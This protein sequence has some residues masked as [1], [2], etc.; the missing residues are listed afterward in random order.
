MHTPDPDRRAEL[1]AAAVA[2]ELTPAEAAELDALRT[3]DP[4]I[5]GEV[6]ELRRITEQLAPRV[7]SWDAARPSV[8]LRERLLAAAAAEATADD[9]SAGEATDA[10]AVGSTSSHRPRARRRWVPALAAAACLVVGAGVGSVTV[11]ATQQDAPAPSSGPPGTLGAVERV[12]FSGEPAQVTIDGSLVAHTWGTETVLEIDGLP[13]GDSYSVV[14]VARDGQRFDSGTFIG[15]T[16][17]VDCRM[18]AAVLRGDVAEIAIEDADGT[19][20]ATAAVP[21]TS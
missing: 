17:E 19:A 5:D 9:E 20:V 8:D 6:E 1:V 2:G 3:V 18:N 10:V 16:V 11:L 12:R 21:P 15:S 7:G 14:V 13:V 4:S